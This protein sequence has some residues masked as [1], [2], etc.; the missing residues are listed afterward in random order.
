MEESSPWCITIKN[1]GRCGKIFYK[2][3]AALLA[4]DWEFGGNDVVVMIWS[5][6][7][8][9]WNEALPW[10]SG[11]KEEILSRIATKVISG[12]GKGCKA[13]FDL[14]DTTIYLKQITS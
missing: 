11:R 9:D 6:H 5:T 8:E 1:M 7:R 4:F 13:E 2:E 3:G 12:P 14:K 10:A